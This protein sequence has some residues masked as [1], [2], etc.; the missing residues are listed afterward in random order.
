MATVS[1]VVTAAD[2]LKQMENELA[3]NS[4]VQQNAVSSEPNGA[5]NAKKKRKRPAKKKSAADESPAASEQLPRQPPSKRRSRAKKRPSQTDVVR[6]ATDFPG[7]DGTGGGGVGG[8]KKPAQQPGAGTLDDILNLAAFADR[9]RQQQPSDASAAT[10][11]VGVGGGGGEATESRRSGEPGVRATEKVQEKKG[12]GEAGSQQHRPE[13]Q[14]PGSQQQQQQQQQPSKACDTDSSVA[15]Y[16]RREYLRHARAVARY[17]K[18][19]AEIEADADVKRRVCELMGYDQLVNLHKTQKKL[20]L[21]KFSYVS[22]APGG[23][24]L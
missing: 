15:A 24:A 10:A 12:G 5:E 23:E 9:Q 20:L 16:V 21:E 17:S 2:V 1:S 6:G 11:V 19:I 14:A 18:K 13:H 22:E 7:R 3:S 8:T 4:I